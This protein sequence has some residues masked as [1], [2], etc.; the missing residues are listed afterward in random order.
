MILTG[1][2]L[3]ISVILGFIAMAN[4]NFL[5]F[6]IIGKI[7]L[8]VISILVLFS[9]GNTIFA[10][11]LIISVILG[12][13]GNLMSLSNLKFISV[14]LALSSLVINIIVIF[15]MFLNI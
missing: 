13:V 11:L 12:V 1:I 7:I 10:I 14:I 6:S 15:N 2:L 5:T 3:I 4:E 9:I 8:G